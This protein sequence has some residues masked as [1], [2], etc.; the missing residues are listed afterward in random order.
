MSEEGS[1]TSWVSAITVDFFFSFL[2]KINCSTP[3]SGSSGDSVNT[4]C[5]WRKRLA[6]R[7]QTRAKSRGRSRVFA[8][9]N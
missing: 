4:R 5:T 3:S 2:F 7:L 6:R 9:T 8:L 1:S